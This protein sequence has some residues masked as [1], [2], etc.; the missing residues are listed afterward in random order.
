MVWLLIAVSI[1]AIV[2]VA[3]RAHSRYLDQLEATRRVVMTV[4]LSNIS[5]AIIE[6]TQFTVDL[7][8]EAVADVPIESLYSFIGIE[9]EACVRSPAVDNRSFN[10]G[11][12][13][14]ETEL[15]EA[16]DLREMEAT[17]REAEQANAVEL[18]LHSPTT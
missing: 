2:F 17:V 4:Q 3:G 18:S 5:P 9:K 16:Y 15:R 8:S 1:C 13:L 12:V 10:H 6:E 14:S 11:P 7:T